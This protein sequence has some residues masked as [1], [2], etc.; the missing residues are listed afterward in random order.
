MV[1][2]GQDGEIGVARAISHSRKE[3]KCLLKSIIISSR[4]LISLNA[5]FSRDRD[6]SIHEPEKLEEQSSDTGQ[7][8]SQEGDATNGAYSSLLRALHTQC[9]QAAPVRKR[10]RLSSSSIP[11]YQIPTTYTTERSIK[12]VKHVLLDV[13]DETD[14]STSLAHEDSSND[15]SAEPECGRD[16]KFS[17][18]FTSLTHLY[19]P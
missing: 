11:A 1:R 2:E 3:Q 15:G 13:V 6:S 4:K 9:S 18:S 14:G 16:G 17:I 8:S 7:S 19:R 12:S 5:N 10:R